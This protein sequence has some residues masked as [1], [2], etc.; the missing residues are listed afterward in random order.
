M[1]KTKT[2]FV[3]GAGAS[4]PFGLPLGTGL[5]DWVLDNFNG[6]TGHAVHLYNT[7]NFTGG[8]VGAFILA[9]RYSGFQSVDAFLE[10][11]PEFMEVGKAVMAIELVIRENQDALWRGAGNWMVYLYSAMIGNS[12]EEFGENEVSFITFNYDRSLEHFLATSLK[13]SFGKSMQDV[14]LVLGNIPVI[15]LHG[16]LGYLPWQNDRNAIPYSHQSITASDMKVF[17]RE[18]KVV[19]EDISDGRDKDFDA[20]KKLMEEASRIYL[21]GFGFG[22]RNVERLGLR[23][24]RA[25][26]AASTAVGLTQ[27]ELNRISTL[28]DGK[29]NL[30]PGSDCLDLLRNF[31]ILD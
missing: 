17:L 15:H 22:A 1:I 13:N 11:R 3:L 8:E 25:G 5:R 29:V 30:R 31:A 28:I 16:R 7:T 2:V 21:L 9:L 18:I 24:L 20:A 27:H 10:R 19:H 6:N 26:I 4:Y 14:A 23:E 12:L